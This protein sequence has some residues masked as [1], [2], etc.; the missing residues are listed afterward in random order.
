MTSSAKPVMLATWSFGLPA[1]LSAWPGLNGGGS[2]LDAVEQAC[3]HAEL[4]TTVDSVGYGGLPDRDGDVT[5][6]GCVMLAPRR[7]GG[8]CALRH[9]PHPVSVARLVMERTPHVLLAGAGAD[10][11]AAAQGVPPGPVRSPVAESAWRRWKEDPRLPDQGLDCSLLWQEVGPSFTERVSPPS[12]EARWAGHDTIGVLSIDRHGVMAGACS[13]SGTPF[14]TPGRVGDSPIIGHGLYVDPR[15]GAAVA[16]GNGEL[17]S[18]TCA[19][20]LVVEML[21]QNRAP[22]EAL[23]LALERIVASF[24]LTPS[25]QVGLIALTPDGCAAS[26]ALRPGFRV[27]LV[28]DAGGR[29]VEA[30]V[31]MGS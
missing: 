24:P 30:D 10:A 25:H 18:A 8:V 4:D 22:R 16:T 28:D 13:T 7:C 23:R 15:A 20:F 19:S 3:R 27:S 12:D 17:M 26:A 21:R 11:F 5:L 6:D 29:V 9:C 31:V 1:C 14:K 2:S